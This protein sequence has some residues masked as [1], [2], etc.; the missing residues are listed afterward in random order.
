MVQLLDALAEVQELKKGS[1]NE[2]SRFVRSQVSR[3]EDAAGRATEVLAR[4]NAPENYREWLTQI[5]ETSKMFN[6]A[7]FPLLEGQLRILDKEW[8]AFQAHEA[9]KESQ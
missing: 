4:G 9:V 2:I 1:K 7:R 5:I 8:I 6:V 3:W